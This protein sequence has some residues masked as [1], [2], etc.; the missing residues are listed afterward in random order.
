MAL[1]FSAFEFASEEFNSDLAR[2]VEGF[3]HSLVKLISQ[4]CARKEAED[5]GT[6]SKK[7]S[8][9]SSPKGK[10]PRKK[11]PPKR[12][13]PS[14]EETDVVIDEVSDMRSVSEDLSNRTEAVRSSSKS[15]REEHN[16]PSIAIGLD[17]LFNNQQ[18]D[19]SEIVEDITPKKGKTTKK[20]KVVK[21]KKEKVVKEKKEKVV[22]EKK[23]K[24]VKEK[25]EKV[26]KEKKDETVSEQQPEPVVVTNVVDEDD[27]DGIDTELLAS[28][29]ST[30]G[31]DDE[32][33]KLS[34]MMNSITIVGQLGQ[35]DEENDYANVIDTLKEVVTS[36]QKSCDEDEIVVNSHEEI[37]SDE[38][39]Q[40]DDDEEQRGDDGQG[41]EDDQG[42]DE[43]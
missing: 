28:Q 42:D 3:T 35:L 11:A 18:Q 43:L 17:D 37:Q 12:G 19:V 36:S 5:D 41:G 10:A 13:R 15:P 30:T 2:L 16:E 26:V 23:E 34:S 27:N 24:V 9:F 8:P 29:I 25:K 38:D 21:E 39:D 14:K 40:G 31:G 6:G 20:E 7:P 22:K 4:E 1:K 33:D 32:I